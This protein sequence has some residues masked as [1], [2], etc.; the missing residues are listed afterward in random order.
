MRVV[1]GERRDIAVVKVV[2][3]RWV[4]EAVIV[5]EAFHCGRRQSGRV[6]NIRKMRAQMAQIATRLLPT[7]AKKLKLG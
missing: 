7:T 3:M 5:V 4:I 1:V 6:R 2:V